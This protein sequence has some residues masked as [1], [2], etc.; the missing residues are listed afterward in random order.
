MPI[1]FDMV[2]IEDKFIS[3]FQSFMD[4]THLTVEALEDEGKLL[5]SSLS[6]YTKGMKI[7][8]DGQHNRH[9]ISGIYRIKEIDSSMTPDAKFKMSIVLIRD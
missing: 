9:R 8:V 7:H 4:E 6:Q 5:Q 1:K 3:F 2:E